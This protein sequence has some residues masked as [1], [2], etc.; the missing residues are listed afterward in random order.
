MLP[1]DDDERTAYVDLINRS[2]FY[3]SLEDKF[4]KEQISNLKDDDLM[5][6]KFFDEAVVAEQFPGDWSK[7]LA[8][9][10]FKWYSHKH[11]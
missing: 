10:F 11:V 2:L 1:A 5:L 3:F 4:L 6:K 7:Q 8:I 9:G